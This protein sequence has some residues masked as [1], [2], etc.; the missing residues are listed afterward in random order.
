MGLLRAQN[1][2]VETNYIKGK[3]LNNKLLEKTNKC[4]CLMFL[5]DLLSK[6]TE[7]SK[8]KGMWKDTNQKKDN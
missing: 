6:D 1:K 3:L 8:V 4:S 7:R 5:K 2:M